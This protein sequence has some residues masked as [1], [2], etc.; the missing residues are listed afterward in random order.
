MGDCASPY[1]NKFHPRFLKTSQQHRQGRLILVPQVCGPLLTE[2]AVSVRFYGEEGGDG[3]GW[4][5]LSLRPFQMTKQQALGL[6]G[7]I[8]PLIDKT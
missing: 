2:L 5:R 6:K 4:R 8:T 3:V 1:Y 7:F